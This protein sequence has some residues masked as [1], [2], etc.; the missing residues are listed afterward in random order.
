MTQ[1]DEYR[2]KAGELIA[3]AGRE[4]RLNVRR[5]C[6]GLAQRYLRLA[7]QAELNSQTDLV[8]QTPP[9]GNRPSQPNSN[10]NSSS[11]RAAPVR[12]RKSTAP[13]DVLSPHHLR[14]GG[15]RLSPLPASSS[16]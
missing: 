11:L 7:E 4:T 13:A 16:R 14:C 8:Y 3:Q 5:E 12:N 1:A 2:L 15:S 10:N 6:L 9:T